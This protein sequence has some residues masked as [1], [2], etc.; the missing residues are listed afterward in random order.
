MLLEAIGS[1]EGKVSDPQAPTDVP[2]PQQVKSI[3][4]FLRRLEFH[5]SKVHVQHACVCMELGVD[6]LSQRDGGRLGPE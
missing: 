1:W 6:W 2:L 5:A 3:E 4:R